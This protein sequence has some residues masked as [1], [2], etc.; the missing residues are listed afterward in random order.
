MESGDSSLE[1][2]YYFRQPNVFLLLI[3]YSLWLH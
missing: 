1:E 2:F 3:S